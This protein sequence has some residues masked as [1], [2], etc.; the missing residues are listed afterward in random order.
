LPIP[1]VYD[2]EKVSKSLLP[3]VDFSD[4]MYVFDNKTKKYEI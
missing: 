3:Y 4:K 1:V 2:H